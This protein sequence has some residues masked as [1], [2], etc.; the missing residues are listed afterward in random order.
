MVQRK[1]R[2][3]FVRYAAAATTVGL[4]GCFGNQEEETTET[5]AETTA[6]EEEGTTEEA[7]REPPADREA[8]FQ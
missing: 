1:T 2:R 3:R 8:Q 7:D 5:A 6:A 4:A